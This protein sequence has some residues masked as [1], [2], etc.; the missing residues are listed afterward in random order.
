MD[1]YIIWWCHI[2]TLLYINRNKFNG[3]KIGKIFQSRKNKK[4]CEIAGRE[5]KRK[6]PTAKK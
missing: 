6:S 4:V 2:H 5:V 1:E 3:N